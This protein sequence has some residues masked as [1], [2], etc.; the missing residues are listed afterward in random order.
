MAVMESVKA[1]LLVTTLSILIALYY[2]KSS[3]QE[4][5]SHLE[6]ILSNLLRAEKKY[7]LVKP[8]Q[9]IVGIGACSDAFV[10]ATEFLDKLNISAPIGSMG[11]PDSIMSPDDLGEIFAF[12]FTQGAAS[13]RY[14]ANRT[15]WDMALE[16]TKT[17][18]ARWVLGGNAPVIAKR[19][20]AEGLKDVTLGAYLSK[21]LFEDLSEKMNIVGQVVEVDDVHIIL[22]YERDSRWQH[23]TAPRAN[24][25]II[26]ADVHNLKMSALK[27]IENHIQTEKPHAFVLGGLQMLDS[28]VMNKDERS[29]SINR[30]SALLSSLNDE[31]LRH[32]ELASFAEKD[33]FREVIDKIVPHADSLGMNEQ[34]LMNLYTMLEDNSV[35][36]VSN[37]HPRIALVLDQMRSIWKVLSPGKLSRLHVHTLA[38]QAIMTK[39]NKW[40]NTM[41]AAA[42][43]SLTAYRHTCSSGEIDLESA[44]LLMDESFAVGRK[45]GSQRIKFN[46]E[47]PVAC[48]EEGNALICVSPVLICTNVKQTA[49][50]GD[51]ISA[52][53]LAMQL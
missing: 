22:E 16:T 15:F 30:L 41:I 44:R 24:R 2:K 32:F 7:R 48:W 52:A 1:G 5:R 37:A 21:P 18:E 9:V 38:F 28:T 27:D 29:K 23:L 51:N 43:A 20:V 17:M 47:K 46:A 31:T 3:D 33:F 14:V 10:E 4:L 40:S 45:E 12:F 19:L 13:E 8:K 39:K 6:T 34:E 36:L 25:F 53:G 35:T 11:H 49:G 50:G 26:H 42:K